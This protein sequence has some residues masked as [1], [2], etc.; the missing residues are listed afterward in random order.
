[1]YFSLSSLLHFGFIQQASG[2]SESKV[3]AV[4]DDDGKDATA[5]HNN[6][7]SQPTTGS[8][9]DLKRETI[10][11]NDRRYLFYDIENNSQFSF[12]DNTRTK[13]ILNSLVVVCILYEAA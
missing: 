9:S 2:E 5:Q 13:G 1:M 6:H 4:D 3:S 11:Q 12:A 10:K 7:N 8:N